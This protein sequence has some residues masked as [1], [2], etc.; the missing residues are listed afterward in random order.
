MEEISTNSTNWLKHSSAHSNSR[1]TSDQRGALKY[2]IWLLSDIHCQYLY[3]VNTFEQYG[4]SGHFNWTKNIVTGLSATSQLHL[5]LLDIKC[6]LKCSNPT[7]QVLSALFSKYILDPSSCCSIVQLYVPSTIFVFEN[8]MMKKI[9]KFPA[10]IMSCLTSMSD[11]L[12]RFT[13]SS[14]F[15]HFKTVAILFFFFPD[16]KND[17]LIFPI[18]FHKSPSKSSPASYSNIYPYSFLLESCLISCHFLNIG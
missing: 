15:I 9:D 14:V 16:Y 12:I 18:V 8:I 2:P 5:I 4:S 3:E 11:L 13:V 7:L 17:D 6:S 1:W 10:L